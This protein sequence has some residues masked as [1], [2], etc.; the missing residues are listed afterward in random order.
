[1]FVICLLT[2]ASLFR[3]LA[4]NT[5][6]EFFN[7]I[8]VTLSIDDLQC[9]LYM[10]SK[11]I[12]DPSLPPTIQMTSLKF[13]VYIAESIRQKASDKDSHLLIHTIE[14]Y[15]LNCLS[16]HLYMHVFRLSIQEI[17][18]YVSSKFSYSNVKVLE[19][20]VHIQ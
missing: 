11:V 17:Y 1:M 16:I 13:L 2:L 6:G 19:N 5:F 14:S 15:V 10:Y 8:R 20:N 4:Y 3:P 9:V 7:H 18:C 12:H